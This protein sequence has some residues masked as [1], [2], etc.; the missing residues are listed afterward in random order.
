MAGTVLKWGAIAIVLLVA[1][2]VLNGFIGGLGQ[3]DASAQVP[4]PGVPQWAPNY[5]MG[6]VYGP[7]AIPTGNPFYSSPDGS[8]GGGGWMP[9][10][11][12]W[13]WPRPMQG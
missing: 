1:W 7:I 9:P 10:R 8:G 2:K 3:S 5:Y 13:G 6:G 12:P 11:Q 4:D